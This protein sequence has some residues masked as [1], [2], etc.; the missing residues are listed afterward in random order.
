I[1][2][3]K[4]D[5]LFLPPGHYYSPIAGPGDLERYLRLR[6]LPLPEQIAGVDLNDT[7]QMG[8]L[9]GM[10]A[11]YS[12]LPEFPPHRIAEAR[13]YYLNPEFAYQDA[14]ALRYFMR[15]HRPT[16]VI[17]V[18]CGHSSTVMLD[19]DAQYLD[20]STAFTFIDPYP[21]RLLANVLE[22]DAARCTIMRSS[23]QD[24]DPDLFSR[25]Q[26]DDLL[27]IDTSHVVKLCGDVNFYL[28]EIFPRLA[29]WRP[30][31]C[32]RHRLSIRVSPE[33]RGRR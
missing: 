30:H 10:Q 12:N 16:R 3:M 8:H 11:E 5:E 21:D 29:S 27:F 20:S 23:V 25:L 1:T 13:Y 22:S 15:R 33:L 24:V 19:C 32:A 28:F 17:E 2:T 7:E 6:A 18:G 31:S 14:V 26:R 4:K 9:R